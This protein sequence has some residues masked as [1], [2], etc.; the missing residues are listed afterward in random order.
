MD[1]TYVRFGTLRVSRTIAH[2]FERA[3]R[4]LSRDGEAAS[5]LHRLERAPH[6]VT[7]RACHNGNDRFEGDTIVWDPHSAMRTTCG[8]YQSP[9]LGLLH[10]EDHARESVYAPAQMRHLQQTRDSRYDTLEEKRVIEG[11]ER[12]AALRLGE[13]VRHDHRGTAYYVKD[14]AMCRVL[15]V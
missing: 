3:Q 11:V 6:V 2:A 7:V 9:A 4:Y 13:G 5:I 15:L 12:R 1:T 8:G 10:E 14:P